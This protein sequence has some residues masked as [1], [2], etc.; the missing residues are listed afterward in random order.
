MLDPN[1][2]T[3]ITIEN[4]LKHPFLYIEEEFE[5]VY[6]RELTRKHK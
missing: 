3:R 2:V 6:K 5:N 1:P 4:A